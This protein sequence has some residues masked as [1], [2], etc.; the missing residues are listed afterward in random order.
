MSED[1]RICVIGAGRIGLPISV[2]LSEVG[3]SVSILE[4]DEG[5]VAEI[6]SSKSPFFEEGMQESL[7]AGVSEGRI[8]ATSEISEISNCMII[9]AIY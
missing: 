2:R 7:S 6:N 3:C 8:K 4:V 1:N 9:S 5:R